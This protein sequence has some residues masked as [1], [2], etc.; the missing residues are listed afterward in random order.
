MNKDGLSD[1]LYKKINE[2]VIDRTS[3]VWMD[4]NYGLRSMLDQVRNLNLLLKDDN[5]YVM[6]SLHHIFELF[7]EKAVLV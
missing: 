7:Q 5:E 6:Q 3:V 4:S 2:S 1:G